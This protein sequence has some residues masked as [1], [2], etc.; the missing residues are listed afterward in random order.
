MPIQWTTQTGALA[1][2]LYVGT[3]AGAKDIIN[4]GETQHTQWSALSLP[5][6]ATVFARIYTKYP[7]GWVSSD[8]TFTVSPVAVFTTPAPGTTEIK[9]STTFAWSTVAG[10]QAYYLYVGSTLGAKDLVNSGEVQTTSLQVAGLPA[11]KTVYARLNTEYGGVWR[12][13]DLT[14][15]VRPVSTFTAPAPKQTTVDPRSLLQWQAVD[16]AQSYYLYVGTQPGL[17]DIVNSGETQ[18]TQWP[19]T[20]VP[21]GNVVFARLYTKYQN[22][23][24]YVDISFQVLPVAVFITPGPNDTQIDSRASITWSSVDG[25]DAYY[26]YVGTTSGA[27]DLIDTGETQAL[28]Q[29]IQALPHD[30][31]LYARIYTKFGGSWRYIEQSFQIV[32]TVATL[33]DPL[34]GAKNVDTRRPARW[35]PADGAQAYYLYVGTTPG[36]KDLV[37]SGEITSTS[38]NISQL[39]AGQ[40]VYA[41]LFTKRAGAWQH[42]DSS[43]Q[44]KPVA[45]LNGTVAS[46]GILQSGQALSW[47]PYPGATTYYVYVGTAPGLTDIANSGE[48][49]NTSYK[50]P[51][52]A[53]G[54]GADQTIYVRLYTLVNGSWLSVDY[55]LQ[56]RAKAVLY[57]PTDAQQ[58]ADVVNLRFAW[59]SVQGAQAYYLYVGTTPG[60]NDV[61]NSGETLAL[62]QTAPIMPGATTLYARIWTKLNAAWRY[63]DSTFSTRP[64][65]ALTY[66]RQ[67]QLSVRTDLPFQ[68]TSVPGADSYRLELGSAP[69]MADLY[70]SG[71]VTT[72]SVTP[73]PLPA[74]GPIYGRIWTHYSGV[75]QFADAVF[76]LD[77]TAAQPTLQWSSGSTNFAARDGLQ[78]TDAPLAASYRL[79]IGTTPGSSDVHDSGWIRTDRRLVSNLSSGPVLY[80]TLATQFLNG[81][82]ASQTFT[83]IVTDPAVSFDDQWQLGLWAVA[84]V[85]GMAPASN[86]PYPNTTLLDAM[87]NQN[88]PTANCTT[89]TQ[90]MLQL[91]DAANAGLDARALNVCLNPNHY[92]CH[93]L[94]EAYIP[95][96]DRWGILDPTFGFAA[97]RASDGSWASSVDL[98]EAT[99]DGDYGRINYI[100]LTPTGRGFANNYYLDYPLLFANVYAPNSTQIINAVDSILPYFQSVGSDTVSSTGSYALRCPAGSIEVAIM[101][102]GTSWPVEDDG[103]TI[104][105]CTPGLENMSS[106]FLS[107]S[108]SPASDAYE[109]YTPQR[110]VFQ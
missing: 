52:T 2:Y 104:I 48:I 79:M 106:V 89:Y 53:A 62:T 101:A 98:F 65:A 3:T 83:F 60:A 18:K 31:T 82:T 4:S 15:N 109:I 88:L 100:L 13:V 66:P 24:R 57:T 55:S 14:L 20:A 49:T 21:V 99:R 78:W 56:L 92:D 35:L 47:N 68:W 107:S 23:W 8:E 90:A 22:V 84:A 30:Q 71:V 16:G 43:F 93:T 40:L 97:Q 12:H 58:N 102:S 34:D 69:G 110:F 63:S 46:T 67:G 45:Y 105:S 33:V 86:L 41:R 59:T 85:R 39:P 38:Y 81:T 36:A 61:I 73:P 80:G 76:T 27:K 50:I 29:S 9:P 74:H 42:V 103:T 5:A 72:T 19:L 28:S 77:S 95:S 70:T 64:A 17:K 32:T 44:T 11:G 91:L 51:L 96:L 37:N 75:W 7:E 94:V 54:I 6:G 25:A 10:A 87:R 1:Y 26:L 108:I